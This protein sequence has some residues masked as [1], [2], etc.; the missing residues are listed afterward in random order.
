MAARPRRF[1]S[2]LNLI[3]EET[4]R[5]LLELLEYGEGRSCSEWQTAVMLWFDEP[6]LRDKLRELLSAVEIGRIRRDRTT[7]DWDPGFTLYC[8]PW[9]SDV[10]SGGRPA[11]VPGLLFWLRREFRRQISLVQDKLREKGQDLDVQ[12]NRKAATR[13]SKIRFSAYAIDVFI[14]G[15]KPGETAVVTGPKGGGKTQFAL[16]HMAAPWIHNGGVV[17][18]NIKVIDLHPEQATSYVYVQT[19]SRAMLAAIQARL[20]GKLVLLLIDEG[21]TNRGRSNSQRRENKVQKDNSAWTRKMGIAEGIIYHRDADVA[22]ELAEWADFRFRKFSQD[23][24]SKVYCETPLLKGVLIDDQPSTDWLKANNRPFLLFDTNDPA[25]YDPDLDIAQ[26][27]RAVFSA[28]PPVDGGPAEVD[29][30]RGVLEVVQDALHG[31]RIDT[32]MTLDQLHWCV[33]HL[34]LKDTQAKPFTYADLF[35]PHFAANGYQDKD[36]AKRLIMELWKIVSHPND[37]SRWCTF[38]R[39]WRRGKRGADKTAPPTPAAIAEFAA[40]EGDDTPEAKKPTA[41]AARS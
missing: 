31:P 20:S 22:S 30:L 12:G 23:E 1:D 32:P 4:M 2:K 19:M 38:C 27:V 16:N 14:Q 34:H 21:A 9:Q 3:S 11:E 17:V 13:E 29:W 6:T 39:M 24:R 26:I 8:E 40:A 18:S 33:A 15:M 5:S 28:A 37:P 25:S 35:A 41:P 36:E 10:E 7:P